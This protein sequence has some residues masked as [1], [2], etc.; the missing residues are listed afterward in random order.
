MAG[1]GEHRGSLGG[2]EDEPSRSP[3]GSIGPGSDLDRS[4]RG[5]LAGQE[6]RRITRNAAFAVQ[7]PR[8]ASADQGW[9]FL[10][11]NEYMRAVILRSSTYRCHIKIT[12]NSRYTSK[13]FLY[14]LY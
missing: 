10:F 3:R 2:A 1:A 8:R 13:T 6:H 12:L 7:D 11:F 4:P 14:V 9:Y 5:S